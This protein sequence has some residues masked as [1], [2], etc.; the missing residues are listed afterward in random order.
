[1]S[2]NFRAPINISYDIS[3]EITLRNWNGLSLKRGF[4]RCG[5]G[6]GGCGGLSGFGEFNG[7]S[8]FGGFDF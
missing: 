5:H 3:S 6:F 2:S 7:F 8:G 1:M 4:C